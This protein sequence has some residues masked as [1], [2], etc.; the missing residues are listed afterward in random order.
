MIAD[1][2]EMGVEG[3]AFS[4]VYFGCHGI[5]W[6][7]LGRGLVCFLLFWSI[8]RITDL[9]TFVLVSWV[10]IGCNRQCVP[11]SPGPIAI[12]PTLSQ[13]IRRCIVTSSRLV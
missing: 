9:G 1:R 2:A 12:H 5:K 11:S 3:E 13:T 7:D 8:R 10:D 6:V 4:D